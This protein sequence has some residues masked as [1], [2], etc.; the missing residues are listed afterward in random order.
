MEL[1]GEVSSIGRQEDSWLL[2]PPLGAAV[3]L[4]SCRSS[5]AMLRDGCTRVGWQEQK[6][7]QPRQRCGVGALDGPDAQGRRRHTGAEASSGW[8]EWIGDERQLPGGVH[9]RT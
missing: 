5:R 2:S 4:G 1:V 9:G 3:V 8:R 6:R 7:P